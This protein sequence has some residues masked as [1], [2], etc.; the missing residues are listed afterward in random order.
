MNFQIFMNA[1]SQLLQIRSSDHQNLCGYHPNYGGQTQHI[2]DRIWR[3]WDITYMN[4]WKFSFFATSFNWYIT[5]NQLLLVCQREFILLKLSFSQHFW[6]G[7]FNFILLLITKTHDSRQLQ[8]ARDSI[9]CGRMRRCIKFEKYS[10]SLMFN[11]HV[12]ILWQSIHFRIISRVKDLTQ[13]PTLSSY[14]QNCQPKAKL[15][16]RLGLGGFIFT[17]KKNR[18]NKNTFPKGKS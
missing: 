7:S 15:K 3:S 1:I 17:L 2:C 8:L 11:I 16:L 10:L 5:K 12:V 13:D 4:I 6:L 14:I 9:S 18:N